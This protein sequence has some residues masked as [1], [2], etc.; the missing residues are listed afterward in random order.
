M[1]RV[2]SLTSIWRYMIERDY[3]IEKRESDLPRICSYVVLEYILIPKYKNI[4][5][6]T[7][8]LSGGGALGRQ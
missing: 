5:M 7:P 4:F 2:R 3:K 6:A 8:F 1:M